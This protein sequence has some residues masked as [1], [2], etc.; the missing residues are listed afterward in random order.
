[1]LSRKLRSRK[2]DEQ[3]I[4]QVFERMVKG[5]RI[6]MNTVMWRKREVGMCHLRPL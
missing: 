1:M 4:E 5:M 2:D 6:E 3:E